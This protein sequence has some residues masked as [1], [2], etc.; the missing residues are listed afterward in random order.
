MSWYFEHEDREDNRSEEEARLNRKE[1]DLKLEELSDH[2]GG[3]GLEC[4]GTN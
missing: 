4:V 1:I 2:V 3:F